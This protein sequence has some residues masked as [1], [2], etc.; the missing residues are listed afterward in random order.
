LT[1]DTAADHGA[2]TL[3]EYWFPDYTHSP[4]DLF[5]ADWVGSCRL[6]EYI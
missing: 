1:E 4:K 6:F 3:V 5:F 2:E